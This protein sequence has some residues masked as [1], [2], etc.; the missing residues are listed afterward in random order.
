MKKYE[1]DQRT[2][3]RMNRQPNRHPDHRTFLQPS[4]ESHNMPDVEME[5]VDSDTYQQ[6]HHGAEYDPDDLWMPEP[7][8]PHV[9]ATGVTIG[10]GS[11]TQRIRI[12]AISELKEI[13]GKDREEGK[14][15]I[16]K[17]KSAFIRDQAPN[18]ER[19]LVFGDL[20]VGPARYWYRQ[21]S[22]S[23]RFNWKE[24][25]NS[26]LVEYAG[27]AMSTSR[28]YYHA[29]KRLEED[30]LHD[31]YRLNVMGMQAKIPVM[32]GLPAA[33][34]EHVNHFIYTLDD[35]DLSNQLLL[36]NVEDADAMQ[37]TLH[38]YQQGRSRQEKVM[39]VSSKFRQK[40]TPSPAFSKPSRALRTVRTEDV[41]SESGSD[42][43]GSDLEG[44]LRS[45]H[46]ADTKDRRSSS[47]D[48]AANARSAYPNTRQ[49]YQDRNM[50]SKPC[51]PYGSTKHGYLGCWKR[52]TC[53]KCGCKGHPS[54]NCFF[55][56]RACGEMYDPR[57]CPMEEFY[58]MICQWYVPTKHAGILPEKAKKM[59]N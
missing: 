5:S 56:C 25:M 8:R 28:Q 9:A 34:K 24:L 30:P 6:I 23:T 13:L 42:T 39:M 4:H 55:V 27:H 33:R 46:V 54:D 12:S 16:G 10:G 59:L 38:G 53:Q 1:A 26:F 50:P 44:R 36:L 22:R 52:L 21:L 14:A 19:C 35:P 3:Q 2:A 45:I 40:R 11:I 47:N 58:N 18:E 49:D 7:R 48:V 29:K 31:L 57:K 51:T 37:K 20:M 32:T 15:R 43:C 41:C 17:V